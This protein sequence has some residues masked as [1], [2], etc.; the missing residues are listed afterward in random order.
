MYDKTRKKHN[1]LCGNGAD[2]RSRACRKRFVRGIRRGDNRLSLRLRHHVR[3]RTAAARARFFGQSLQRDDRGRRCAVKERQ[4][5]RRRK[6][7]AAR[8]SRQGQYFRLG[9]EQA[10]LDIRQRRVCEQQQRKQQAQSQIAYRRARR[11]GYR[12]QYRAYRHVQGVSSEPTGA[13]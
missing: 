6:S 10:R 3:Q 5:R 7:V 2:I 12:I 9:G 1:M 11:V 8:G 13:R 4:N